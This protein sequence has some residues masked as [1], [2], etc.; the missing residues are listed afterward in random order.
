MNFRSMFTAKDSLQTT[1]AFIR[2][3]VYLFIH[4][5]R[6]DKVYSDKGPEFKSIFKQFCENPVDMINTHPVLKTAFNNAQKFFGYLKKGQ[7]IRPI[8]WIMFNPQTGSDRRTAIVEHFNRTLKDKLERLD[9][10]YNE[11]SALEE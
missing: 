4:G 7:E 6:V 11:S 1:V 10:E 5:K 2:C 8:E 3:L 9:L